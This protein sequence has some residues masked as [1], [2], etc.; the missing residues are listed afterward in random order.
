MNMFPNIDNK[1]GLLSVNEALTDINFDVDSTQCIEDALKICLTC[2]NSKFNH[3]HFLQIDGTTQGPHVSCSNS[4][5]A[6]TK[7]D[8]LA[9]NFHL[10]LSVWKR[11]RD[12]IFVL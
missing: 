6:M 3:Q 5:I 10:K 2:S 11:F 9:N 1:S 12:D 4:D 7:Y 8:S